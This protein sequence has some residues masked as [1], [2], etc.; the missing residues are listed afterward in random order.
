MFIF[1][2]T[3]SEVIPVVPNDFS[4]SAPLAKPPLRSQNL[5][6]SSFKKN[7]WGETS[8]NLN[9]PLA[10]WCWNVVDVNSDIPGTVNGP[11]LKQQ[12]TIRWFFTEEFLLRARKV[13]LQHNPTNPYYKGIE[14]EQDFNQMSHAKKNRPDTKSIESWLFMRGSFISWLK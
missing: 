6:D 11:T 4:F 5:S 14:K 10:N 12:E 9:Q 13:T 8:F 1:N 3:I 2:K 7:V